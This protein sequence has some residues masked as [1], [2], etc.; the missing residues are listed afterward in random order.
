M[1]T[2]AAKTREFIAHHWHIPMIFTFGFLL[3]ALGW[4]SMS[5]AHQHKHV[6]PAM[7]YPCVTHAPRKV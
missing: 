5:R 2:S 6:K 4:V 3:L 7:C 1:R